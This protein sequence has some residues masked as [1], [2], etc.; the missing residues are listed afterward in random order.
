MGGPNLA[1]NA[2][3]PNNKYRNNYFTIQLK[4]VLTKLR[5]KYLPKKTQVHVNPRL[6]RLKNYIYSLSY[7]L[8]ELSTVRL[9]P[10]FANLL[11]DPSKIGDEKRNFVRNWTFNVQLTEDARRLGIPES[12]AARLDSEQGKYNDVRLEYWLK[13]QLKN[14][15]LV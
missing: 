2:N 8:T 4:E 5:R 11:V 15:V 7:T 13:E 10:E 9:S 14:R 12:W 1:T 3:K 6:N